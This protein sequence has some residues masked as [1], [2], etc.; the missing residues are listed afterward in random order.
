MKEKLDRLIDLASEASAYG[1]GTLD[2]EE[3]S[4]LYDE[5]VDALSVS[6]AQP[7]DSAA[8]HAD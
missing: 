4:R 2:S 1:L 3:Y 6:P 7:S 8:P 5:L